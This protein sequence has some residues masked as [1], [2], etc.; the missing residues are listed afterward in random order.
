MENRSEKETFAFEMFSMTGGGGGFAKKK[1]NQAHTHI[2]LRIQ[3][4]TGKALTLRANIK[5]QTRATR[6]PQLSFSFA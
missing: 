3:P 6:P 1:T 5:S 2:F 4:I